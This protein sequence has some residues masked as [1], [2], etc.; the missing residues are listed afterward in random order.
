MHTPSTGPFLP[1]PE[2]L[3]KFDE[4]GLPVEG[5]LS[6]EYINPVETKFNLTE[7]LSRAHDNEL[8]PTCLES[9]LTPRSFSSSLGMDRER[10]YKMR[11]WKQ[12]LAKGD[13]G[14]F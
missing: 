4:S 9:Y 13:A 3:T 10:F 11:P 14:L 12:R 1:E 5:A 2:L 7:V 6:E 8:D